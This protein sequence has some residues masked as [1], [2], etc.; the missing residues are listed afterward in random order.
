MLSCMGYQRFAQ[1]IQG[2]LMN[3]YQE[4]KVLT[5]DVGGTATT[6]EFTS[7]VIQEIEIIQKN[8]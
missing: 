6:Q 3:V 5:K 1:V 4:G 7:R 2:A 8:K